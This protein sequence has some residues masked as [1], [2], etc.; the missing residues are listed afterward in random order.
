MD[1]ECGQKRAKARA[2]RNAADD[3]DV[4]AGVAAWRDGSAYMDNAGNYRTWG[5]G[6]TPTRAIRG[7][8]APWNKAMKRKYPRGLGG[9]PIQRRFPI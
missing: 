3:A 2:E 9:G 8:V 1:T 7:K 5:E 4:A 6:T